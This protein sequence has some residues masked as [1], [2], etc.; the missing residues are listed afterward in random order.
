MTDPSPAPLVGI[1][2]Y[3]R[4]DADHPGRYHLPGEYVD[5]V[6]RAGGV[7]VLLPPGGSDAE[8]AALLE[9]VD[10]FVLAGG[11]DIDPTFYGAAPHPTLERVDVARD[12]FELALA[13]R[14]VERALPTLAIC[15]GCQVLNV[16]LGGTLHQHLPEVVGERLTHARPATDAER[17][18]HAVAVDAASRLAQLMGAT[19]PVPV[20]SHHQA[21][22]RVAPSLRAVARAEDGTVEALELPE[23]PWLVAVQWHPELSAAQDAS[24][25]RIFDQL[26]AAAAARRDATTGGSK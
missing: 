21:A 10:G 7:P 12:R 11:G 23:H 19:A 1:T 26:V 16:A 4:D 18:R 2:T 15:R 24:Q 3:G 6:R 8:I 25:Q 9:R 14:L 20:S 13:R 22:D 5:A 17:P